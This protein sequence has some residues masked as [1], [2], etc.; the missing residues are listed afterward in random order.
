MAQG[1][2]SASTKL[3]HGGLRYLEFLEVR[4]VRESLIERETLLKAMP[5]IAWPMRFV[6]P[7]HKEQRFEGDTPVGRILRFVMPWMRGRRPSLINRQP[8]S[9]HLAMLAEHDFATRIEKPITTPSAIARSQLAKPFK[10]LSDTD[11]NTSGIYLLAVPQA[12]G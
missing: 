3:I 11:L 4:L 9:A 12:G 5:H 10:D 6:L 8:C 2:S 7:Y 1:T